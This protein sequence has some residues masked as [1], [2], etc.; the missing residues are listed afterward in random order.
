MD[1]QHFGITVMLRNA[2]NN[3]SI[4]LPEGFCWDGVASLCRV[5]RLTGFVLQGAARCGVPRN[6]PALTAMT[7]EFCKQVQYGRRQDQRLQ[8]LLER[9]EE[10]GIEYMPVKGAVIKPMYPK[11]ECRTMG[12]ADL[13]IRQEQFPRIR[14]L[15][16]DMGME[17]LEVLSDYESAWGDDQLKI[18]LHT[19]L[20]SKEL[21]RLYRYYDTGWKFAKKQGDSCRYLLSPEDHLVFMVGHFAKHY[22]NGSICAK[23][24]CDFWIWLRT[25][26]DMDMAYVQRELKTLELDAFYGNLL[27][28]LS[29]WFAGEEATEAVELITAAAFNGG[30]CQENESAVQS[31]MVHTAEGEESLSK[32]KARW[33]LRAVFPSA[34]FLSYKYPVLKK[35][36]ILLPFC[37]VHRWFDAVFRDRD[38]LRR[39][40]VVAKMNEKERAAYRRHMDM[41]GLERES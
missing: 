4:P 37:W 13:L 6:H 21:R 25:Y 12:D 9:F 16:M 36:P 31:R 2:L 41:V 28:L 40:M 18:E 29:C 20:V 39:G 22:M 34:S 35:W 23:D 33:F 8:Q 10:A 3:E 30:V 26:P 5:H 38:K 11:P 15:V 24:I 27:Q 32:Q 1:I 17:K 19:T 14:Q 7:L